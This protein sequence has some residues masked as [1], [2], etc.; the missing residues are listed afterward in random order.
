MFMPVTLEPGCETQEAI[1]TQEKLE[2]LDLHLWLG[3][4]FSAWLIFERKSGRISIYGVVFPM[5]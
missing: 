1:E 5:L 2:L 3:H 4:S